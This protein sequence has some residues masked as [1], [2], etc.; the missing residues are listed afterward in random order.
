MSRPMSRQRSS[1]DLLAD[2]RYAYAEACLHEGDATGAAEM[3]EQALERAPRYAAAWFLLGRARE[4][5]AARDDD[6]AGHRAAL[7]AYAVALDI[8][9]DDALG[10]RLHLSR[11]G[12][13]DAAG[14][15]TPGYVRALFDDYAPRFERHLVHALAY[16]GPEMLVDALDALPDAPQVY[17]E[18]LDLGCGT[19][20]VGR[21]LDTRAGR[22]VGCDLSPGMLDE[23]RRGG[24]YAYLIEADLVRF[25]ADA[26]PGRADLVTAA[27][28]FIYVGDIRPAL[29]AVARALK[30]GGIAAFTVQS[31]DADLD[32][33]GG[34]GE[35]RLG[36]DG[37]YAQS[38][39][40]V[41]GAA[42]GAGL[43]VMV[44]RPA[45]IRRQNGNEV[46][47]RIVLTRKGGIRPR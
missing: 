37:R 43:T 33:S 47:G 28:V 29:C 31:P 35:V 26:P 11:L 1:G 19:G 6:P 34:G 20:L 18:V 15:M 45:A 30:P 14:A 32:A 10:A 39:A 38:D 3:A 9:P 40:H 5:L 21:A 13:I 8:D 7:R 25:L 42:L 24:R 4:A 16:R 46:G 27:D 23:A 36:A 2:R 22:I 12:E 41:E 17:P 44:L